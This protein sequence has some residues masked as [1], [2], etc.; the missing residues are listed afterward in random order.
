MQKLLWAILFYPLCALLGATT[1]WVFLQDGQDVIEKSPGFQALEFKVQF[2]QDQLERINASLND[3]Q[4]KL[5]DIASAVT[6]REPAEASLLKEQIYS[7]TKQL[8]AMEKNLRD[9]DEQFTQYK[10]TISVGRS[11]TQVSSASYPLI[12]ESL[13]STLAERIQRR[14]SW[15]L[16]YPEH[17]MSEQYVEELLTDLLRLKDANRARKIFR[18]HGYLLKGWRKDKWGGKIYLAL[19]ETDAA[20]QY[21]QKLEH[22]EDCP[23][24]ARAEALLMF[25]MS[26]AKDGQKE[27]AH[28]VFR[29]L[30]T[31]YGS[32]VMPE[33]AESVQGAQEQLNTAPSED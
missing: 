32:N 28:E 26:L 27:E 23:E 10:R 20:R 13:A 2:Q 29:R 9:Q 17:S 19:G 7:L 18:Q 14:E 30:I 8:K 24:S 33:I 16:R 21:L 31:D 25:G 1:M 12:Q 5:S 15:L 3:F 4:T 22:C 6:S 11:N